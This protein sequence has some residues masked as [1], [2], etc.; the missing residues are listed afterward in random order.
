MNWKWLSI[1]AA[2]L[3]TVSIWG[4]LGFPTIATGMDIKD[5]TRNQADV[6]IEVYQN[7]YRSWLG[8]PKPQDE[9]AKRAREIEIQRALK[10]LERAEQRKIELG[11]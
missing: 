1:P 10:Q 3:A 8:L 9:D 11:K 2:I 7:K 4:A 5:L 6:A